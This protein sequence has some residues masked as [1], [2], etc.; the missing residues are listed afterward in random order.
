MWHAEV[1]QS[2]DFSALRTI[3]D[4]S[5]VRQRDAVDRDP[6][7]H[8]QVSLVGILRLDTDCCISPRASGPIPLELAQLEHL[9][10]LY[11]NSNELSGK[12]RVV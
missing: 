5:H 6:S 7:H 4:R 2:I 1:R 10:E 12:Y 11:L 9:R 8:N 3:K